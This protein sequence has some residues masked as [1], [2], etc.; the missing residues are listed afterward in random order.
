MTARN[1]IVLNAGSSSVKSAVFECDGAGLRA[2]LRI[3]VHGL[4]SPAPVMRWHADSQSGEE[5]VAPDTV[6]HHAA[7]C[8]WLLSRVRAWPHLAPPIAAGHRIV[9]GGQSFAQPVRLNQQTLRALA[10]L[11][12]LAPLHQDAGLAG[13]EAVSQAWPGLPQVACFDTAF[14]LDQPAVAHTYALP[15]TLR[16]RGLRRYGFHGLSCEH[17]V[18]Q[19]ATAR[20][21]L[22]G[23]RLVVAH[24]GSG[25]SLT[26]IRNRRSV[27]TTMGFSTLEGPPMSTR[28]GSLDPG[29]L[30]HLLREGM[31]LATLEDL[32]YH[33]SGLRG[34]SGGSGDMAALLDREATDAD[35]AFA[36]ACY[37]YRIQRE[38]GSLVAALGGLDVLVFT[39]GIGENGAAIR[40]RIVDGLRWLGIA[41][42]ASANDVGAAVITQPSSAV[43][44]TVITADEEIVIARATGELC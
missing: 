4:G 13:V 10:A 31:S 22:A 41:L 14:H 43:L 27:A 32:L 37:V 7:A 18:Q 26:A 24:L 42:D 34:L 39:G 15:A 21:D 44:G 25:T 9:H 11:R 23:G 16:Q 30:L 8:A 28:S 36:I 33:K 2:R 6:R 17:C 1:L 35:A 5:A 12:H 20:P 3:A 29:I 19:L 38:V 40:E